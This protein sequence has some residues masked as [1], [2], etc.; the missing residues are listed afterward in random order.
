MSDFILSCCSTAD[1]SEQFFKDR[2][3][4]VLLFSYTMDGDVMAITKEANV[5]DKAAIKEFNNSRV[6]F[7][8]ANDVNKTDRYLL[9]KNV[10][11]EFASNRHPLQTS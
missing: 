7:Y 3:I 9:T 10:A 1:M 4:N 6:L 5:D 2:G 8:Q 11:H